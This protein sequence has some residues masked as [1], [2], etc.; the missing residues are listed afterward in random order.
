MLV[1]IN[2]CLLFTLSEIPNSSVAECRMLSK[3]VKK[4]RTKSLKGKTNL[5]FMHPHY[6]QCMCAA[7][8]TQPV[9][10]RHKVH[11]ASVCAPQTAHSQCMCATN[12]TQPVYVRHKLHDQKLV[13][14]AQG[15]Q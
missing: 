7:K 14:I 2:Y 4:V 13:N 8:C 11:T 9:Y 6:G 5:N 15:G 1:F 3:L 10:V 12:C